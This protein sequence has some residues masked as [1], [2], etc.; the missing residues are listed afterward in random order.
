MVFAFVE[1]REISGRWYVGT[2]RYWKEEGA[3]VR[4]AVRTNFVRESSFEAKQAE[5]NGLGLGSNW[6]GRKTFVTKYTR[7]VNKAQ[8]YIIISLLNWQRIYTG[9]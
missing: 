7:W 4:H 5:E 6:T 2:R 3:G 9:R 8:T 1:L